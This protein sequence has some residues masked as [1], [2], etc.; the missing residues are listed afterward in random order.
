MTIYS[1]FD[2]KSGHW[3]DYRLSFVQYPVLE[4]LETVRYTKFDMGPSNDPFRDDSC[5]EYNNNKNL[6]KCILLN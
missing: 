2:Q 3:K 1:G 4:K 5:K 6:N